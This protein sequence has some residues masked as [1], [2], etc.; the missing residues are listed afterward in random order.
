MGE[1]LVPVA[2][3]LLG[4]LGAWDRFQTDGHLPCYGNESLWGSATVQ[5]TDFI[6]WT[7]G[8]TTLHREGKAK[9]IHSIC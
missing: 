6:K 5:S 3:T 2:R 8:G 1:S 4:E 9:A 7:G